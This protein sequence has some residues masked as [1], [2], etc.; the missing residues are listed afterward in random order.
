M[1]DYQMV[2]DESREANEEVAELRRLLEEAEARREVVRTGQGAL[3]WWSV[4]YAQF[5]WLLWGET[6]QPGE[7]GEEDAAWYELRIDQLGLPELHL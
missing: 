4:L 3:T 2:R 5:M 6:L 1:E 7:T